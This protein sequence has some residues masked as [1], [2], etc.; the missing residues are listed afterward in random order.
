MFL[1]PSHNK[2]I[3]AVG[4]RTRLR[5]SARHRAGKGSHDRP[6]PRPLWPLCMLRPVRN[7]ACSG[8]VLPLLLKPRGCFVLVFS[9]WP[10]EDAQNDSAPRRL[11]AEIRGTAVTFSDVCQA[12]VREQE[13]LGSLA[14]SWRAP[15]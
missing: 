3:L 2:D 11:R 5:Q 13:L 4:L 1:N 14:M 15:H 10:E 8:S 9:A 7:G 6:P 12:A